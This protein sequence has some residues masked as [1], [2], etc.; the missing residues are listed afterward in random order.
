LAAVEKRYNHQPR[1]EKKGWQDFTS[2]SLFTDDIE[3]LLRDPYGEIEYES[4]DL[5]LDAV[6][7]TTHEF[8]RY[9]R[10][11]LC[12][13]YCDAVDFDYSGGIGV[14]EG[15]GISGSEWRRGM[16]AGNN[17]DARARQILADPSGFSEYTVKFVK[18]LQE[19]WS[20]LDRVPAMI[21]PSDDEIPF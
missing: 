12:T 9:V 16:R 13:E 3:S 8:T 20:R 21:C 18:T 4:L 10:L 1:R 5:I 6:L 15:Y 7:T 19:E 17:L 11:D 14:P 2:L